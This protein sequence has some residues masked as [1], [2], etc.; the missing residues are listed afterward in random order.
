M[1][2]R[3][4]DIISAYLANTYEQFL[5]EKCILT[6]ITKP[7]TKTNSVVD[8]IGR[9][10][11]IVK[12]KK[13]ANNPI[14]SVNYL[15]E[16]NL[17]SIPEEFKDE[18]L[19]GIKNI[20]K[21]I[22]N[23]SYIL[24]SLAIDYELINDEI[25]D[26]LKKKYHESKFTLRIIGGN[27][28]IDSKLYEKL[29]FIDEIVVSQIAE[30][31]VLLNGSNL[32]DNQ[33]IVIDNIIPDRKYQPINEFYLNKFLSNK[34]CALVTSKI[35][36]T[37]SNTKRLYFRMYEPSKYGELVTKLSSYG[38][39]EK[40]EINLLGNPLIDKIEDFEFIKSTKYKITVTFTTNP[41]RI[42]K[43][44]KEPY[45]DSHNFIEELECSN[46]V[47]SFDYLNIL[48]SSNFLQRKTSTLELSPFEILVYV[49]RYVEKNSNFFI[50]NSITKEKYSEYKNGFATLFSILLRRLN[51]PVLLYT[52]TKNLKNICRIIDKKYKMDRI[53]TFDI[54]RDINTN[55]YQE[56]KIYSFTYFGLS[57]LSSMNESIT[58]YLTIPAVLSIS[59]EDYL[60]YGN[61]S[62]N[63]YIKLYNPIKSHIDFAK[64]ALKLF[65]FEGINENTSIDEFYDFIAD[66]QTKKGLKKVESTAISS[67][68]EKIVQIEINSNRKEQKEYEIYNSIATNELYETEL[69]EENQIL[70][71]INNKKTKVVPVLKTKSKSLN[72]DFNIEEHIFT[73]EIE[74]IIKD[75]YNIKEN[76]LIHLTNNQE[77]INHLEQLLK[78]TLNKENEYKLLNMDCKKDIVE[79]LYKKYEDNLFTKIP[80]KLYLYLT[81]TLIPELDFIL[82]SKELNYLSIAK[83]EDYNTKEFDKYYKRVER[84]IK[85]FIDKLIDTKASKLGI[86]YEY[87]N[88]EF[89]LKFKN[90]IIK[91]YHLNLVSADIIAISNIKNKT[92]YTID[93]SLPMIE[94][95][96]KMKEYIEVYID[97]LISQNKIII[98]SNS[99]IN[100]IELLN[101]DIRNEDSINTFI[102]LEKKLSNQ[103]KKLFD[104]R[105]ELSNLKSTYLSKYNKN[106]Q[107]SKEVKKVKQEKHIYTIKYTY[108]DNLLTEIK[109]YL[110]SLIPTK[111]VYLN[112]KKKLLELIDSILSYLNRR[113]MFELNDIS[114]VSNMINHYASIKKEI[115]KELNK[116]ENPSDTDDINIDNRKLNFVDNTQSI[117]YNNKS[118]I[119]LETIKVYELIK[120]IVIKKNKK[121]LNRLKRN[122]KK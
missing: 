70:V 61:K 33:D 16:T 15:D 1:L 24:Y 89:S 20:G 69:L 54:T 50:R 102:E 59:K 93:T 111:K 46:K 17:E 4:Q 25:I 2:R 37:I 74:N 62:Y 106:I 27:F 45:S 87:N 72:E 53:I 32:I 14:I 43:L 113:S 18:Y 112:N 52:S 96:N 5:D 22:I 118:I 83:E 51:I 71:N 9:F 110:L 108:Y 99:Y 40:V 44:T 23:N 49:Y 114:D 101:I 26:M 55:R 11:P 48:Y 121:S 31:I 29:S 56:H 115:L 81:N 97:K 103:E 80:K 109:E 58:D 122:S 38:L 39:N 120:N 10:E 77:K 64:K 7:K 60:E 100:E 35:N 3:S 92:I 13:Y 105:V 84:K 119:N 116:K 107:L 19:K 63:R 30:D 95:S 66:Y 73:K 41:D 34:E 75:I 36:A 21:D 42:E 82:K 98:K 90:S 12:R 57:P 117:K 28:C 8:V 68:V 79:R 86:I 104:K 76:E 94:E 65:E 88:Y 85:Y 6:S 47:D 91:D 78:D 67:A